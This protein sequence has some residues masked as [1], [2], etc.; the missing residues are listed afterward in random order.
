MDFALLS[1]SSAAPLL[2]ALPAL[3][4]PYLFRRR[5]RRVVVPSL[6][7]Y[8][9]LASSARQGMWGRLR[10]SPLFFLHLLILLL[11][12]LIAARPVVRSPGGS[13]AFVLDTS[14]SMQARSPDAAR[15]FDLAKHALESSLAT[16]PEGE[17]IGLFTSAPSPKKIADSSLAGDW[18]DPSL[19][20]LLAGVEVTDTP[21]P[22]DAVLS[23]FF[24]QLLA[25]DGFQRLVFF[26][27]RPLA[28]SVPPQ[29]SVVRLGEA[30]PNLGISGFRLHRSP[31][32][33]GAVE[34]T[35]RV[36][37]GWRVSLEDAETGQELQSL[38][39]AAGR[40]QTFS[41]SDLPVAR[42]YR[43][44]LLIEDGLE[45]DN[46]AY[47]VL[48][49][50]GSVS[51]LLVSP[52]PEGA[53]G[54]SRIPA[55]RLEQVSP[56]DYRPDMAARFP[57]VI[58]HLTAPDSLPPSNAAFVLPPEGNAVFPLDR[59][60][61]G[62]DITRWTVGHPL[63]RYVHFPL[64]KPAFGQAFSPPAWS[65]TVV[66]ATPGPLIL[67]GERR[68]YRY[69]AVGFDLLPYLGRRNLP[70]SILTLNLLDWLAGRVGQASSLKTGVSL[71]LTGQAPQVS[72]PD[73]QP[74]PVAGR[75]LSLLQQ[76]VYRVTEHG[77]QRR[78][79]VNISSAEESRLGR[80]LRLD[81]PTPTQSEHTAQRPIWPWLVVGVLLL[82]GLERWLVSRKEEA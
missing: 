19:G 69:A 75:S 64:L 21:A 9:G 2:L 54:L 55:L 34:A 6:F 38:L 76:G 12:I 44:R 26:T 8:E 73:G 17:R 82:L 81:V 10:L 36:V 45:L 66:H 27:D 1:A 29:V 67:A 39:P 28:S 50:R 32:F 62:P 61:T 68:G 41:L 42:T 4:V 49:G 72:G 79:A 70:A 80:P 47:A 24:A 14:A 35:L 58:F 77:H 7:L 5:A 56:Q 16:I 46:E 71:S 48:P 13:V 78:L 53:A 20:R 43:A 57:F 60:A 22:S 30:G 63:V 3:L 11:L 65:T 18:S 74:I 59:A 31:F 33:P 51:G 25:E 40:D 52:L 37:G 23:V 15:V